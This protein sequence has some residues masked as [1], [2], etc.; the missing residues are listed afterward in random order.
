MRNKSC[1]IVTFQTER[2]GNF[3][4]P[5]AV[6][7][8]VKAARRSFAYQP[9][10]ASNMVNAKLRHCALGS[11]LRPGTDS[12]SRER[13]L[14]RRGSKLRHSCNRFRRLWNWGLIALEVRSSFSYLIGTE[15]TR[16]NRLWARRERDGGRYGGT[17]NRIAAGR[18]F[19][20]WMGAYAGGTGVQCRHDCAGQEAA[21]QCALCES[22]HPGRIPARHRALSSQRSARY[23]RRR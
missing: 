16:K 15:G 22:K 17:G 23:D 6:E 9:R 5:M 19:A 1:P 4:R 20:R 8:D 3:M 18:A 21:L 2:K 11:A 12:P 13:R 10:G 14:P 7:I